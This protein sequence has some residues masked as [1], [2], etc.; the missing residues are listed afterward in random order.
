V[1]TFALQNAFAEVVPWR[2]GAQRL[3]ARVGRQELR[4]GAERLVSPSD[5]T[6][7]RRT[8][9]GATLG[10]E[11]TR[12]RATAFWTRPVIVEE[13]DGNEHHGGDSFYGVYATAKQLPLLA[14]GGPSL[15]LYWLG[16]NRDDRAVNGTTGNE[17]RHTIGT[18]VWGTLGATGFDAELEAAIQLGELGEKS[19]RAG[20]LSAE[21]GYR[22]PDWWSAPRFQLGADWASGDDEPGGSVQTFDPLFPL[23]HRYLGEIDV[24]GRSNVVA[25][26]GGVTLRPFPATT[27]KLL[28]HRFWRA[29]REDALYAATG[30]LL[31]DG[32]AARARSVGTEIDLSIAYRI[33][34][35]AQL[36]AGYAHYFPDDFIESSGP[37]RDIDFVYVFFE[38]EL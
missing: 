20:M 28:V 13:H 12:A 37:S 27:A 11:L 7:P 31:R 19:L 2:R 34:P 24:Q 35:H 32:A 10:V 21:L 25:L 26:S 16:V 1:D 15:D 38:Y 6:N 29:S 23:G 36:G 22:R 17:R 5:W 14:G 30:S 33:D 3:V 18:R 9:D 4:F 8:F